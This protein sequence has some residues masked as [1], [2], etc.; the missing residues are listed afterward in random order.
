M[1]YIITF[2]EEIVPVV[3][4]FL[5]RLFLIQYKNGRR[6]KIPAFRFIEY[7]CEP[8]KSGLSC[9]VVFAPLETKSK[10]KS[11]AEQSC[12]DVE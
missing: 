1:R 5:S 12:C 9:L 10:N 7:V 11:E 4:W 6:E 3:K 8:N 2:M